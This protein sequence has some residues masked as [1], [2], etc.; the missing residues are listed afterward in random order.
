MAR[1]RLTDR[2]CQTARPR[3]GESRSD[4][5]DET[6]RGLILRVSEDR[7]AWSFMFTA[8]NG[9][10]ARAP[11]GTYPAVSLAA[12]RGHALEASQHLHDGQDP[13]GLFSNSG[14]MSVDMLVDQY[15]DMHV[16]PLRTAK[17]IERRLRKNVMP[18]IGTVKIADL[19]RRDI[20][21]VINPV[22]HRGA[23]VEAARVY[24][25]LRSMLRWAVE[26]GYLDRN[27]MDG[28]RKPAGNGPRERVLDDQ[29]I[30]HLW[31][32]LPSAL[33]RSKAI[34]RIIKLCL[35]TAQRVGEVAGMQVSELDL[36]RGIWSLPGARTK[37]GF[38]HEIPLSGMAIA[39]IREALHEAGKDAVFVFPSEGNLAQYVATMIRRAHNRFG[40]PHWTAHDLRRTAL[41]GMSKIGIAPL[42]LGHVAN[43]RSMTKAGITLGV[44]V[45][46]PHTR[47]KAE[48]LNLWAERLE[49]VVTGGADV[50]PLASKR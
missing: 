42:T 20:S 19:H 13:R 29:E 41:T 16:R 45:Q 17:A 40:I 22:L 2:F 26:K 15:L 4:F 48:A 28:T 3:L 11:L 12:A 9:K 37:N 25:D 8:A 35:L 1:I 38:P 32:V 33:P 39:V 21:R 23:P 47:E 34:Q 5:Y 18:V 7:K 43:H 10:R 44:Y 46:N 31:S 50:I 6:A 14:A 36:K 30:R 49:A 27:P 24:E